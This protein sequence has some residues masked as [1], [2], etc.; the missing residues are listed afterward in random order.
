MNIIVG[1]TGATGVIYG[2]RLLEAFKKIKNLET[3]L[4]ISDNAREIIPHETSMKVKKVEKLASK[5]Y[6]INDLSAAISSGSCQRDAMVIAPCTIKTMSLI[7]NSINL[8]LLVRAADVTLKERKPLILMVR[9]TPL[10]YGHLKSMLQ[11]TE[12]GAI[13][14]PPNPV[15]YHK[16]ET[17]DDIIK[18]S[19][20][21]ILD[22][23]ELPNKL[24]KRWEG[25]R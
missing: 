19:I 20:G 10:H 17:I 24:V 14:M 16:P 2:V 9:E 21:R 18:P 13:I 4:I 12:M 3:H 23:L 15:F 6:D 8:N 25:L 11:L 7:A 5:T 1:I 22:I